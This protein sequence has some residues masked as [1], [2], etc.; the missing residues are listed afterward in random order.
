MQ[1]TDTIIRRAT[2]SDIPFLARMVLL[3][4][5]SGHEL[6]SYKKMFSLPDS[7]LVKKF[8]IVLRNEQ[9]GHGLTYRSFIV[10]EQDGMLAAVASSY[11]EGEY[12]SSSHL[13]TGALMNG[14]ELEQIMRGYKKN[15]EYKDVQI[16]KSA[17]TVQLD[18][19]AILEEFR[20][21]GL[22]KLIFDAHTENV[23]KKNVTELEIQV[24]AG[25]IAAIKAYEKLGYK[26]KIEKW[27]KN[28]NE[29][30]RILMSKQL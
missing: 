9:E 28:K 29:G 22:L 14:F 24:W 30:G 20:G 10:A 23:R 1:K 21:K 6:I 4:E 17:G 16:V 5:T 19:V 2:E 8:E 26:I 18:S 15:A 25:N 13:M 7:D 3:A 12:G 27:R 11:I